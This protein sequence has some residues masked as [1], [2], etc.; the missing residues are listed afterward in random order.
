VYRFLL[1]P[2]WIA[3]TLLMATLVVVMVNLAFWQLRRLEERQDLNRQITARIEVPAG[4]LDAVLAAHPEP[5]DAQ[6][7]SVTASG[8]YEADGQVL[9]RDRSLNGTAGFNV[10]TPLRLADGR[11]LAVERGF[12]PAATVIPAPPTGRVA[13]EGRLRVSQVKKS[14]WQRA[15]AATGVLDTLSR[16]DVARLDQQVGGDAVPMYVEVTSSEPAD[17]TV[18]PIPLPERGDGPHLGYAGQWFLFSAAAI[19]GYIL[20]IRKSAGTRRDAAT[21]AA[22]QAAVKAASLEDKAP[23]TV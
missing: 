7:R 13:I 20:A 19:L 21:K 18:A 22:A 2:K 23:E 3:F 10:V 14:S 16:A 6:W 11:F 12:I 8:F 15:D 17:D 4:S 5:A 9:I 1:R